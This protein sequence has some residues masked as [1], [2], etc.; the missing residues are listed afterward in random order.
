MSTPSTIALEGAGSTATLTPFGAHLLSFSPVPSRAP[1]AEPAGPHGVADTAFWK[2][3]EKSGSGSTI[4]W[5]PWDEG[6]A[7]LSDVEDDA[8]PGFLCV[9]SANVRDR[10]MRIRAGESAG[11]SVSIR[12][13]EL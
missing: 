11:F 6:A 9:E 12:A 1:F 8:W 2:A 13:E 5:N 10:V 4:I 3:V 7:A